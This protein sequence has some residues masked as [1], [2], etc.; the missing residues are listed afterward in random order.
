MRETATVRVDS[1]ALVT[2]RQNRYSVPVALAGLRV[3]AAVGARGIAISHGGEQVA[4]H[5]RLHGR[6]GTSAR[7]DH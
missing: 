1:K 7:L 3:A 5:E 4:S 6:F 2:V